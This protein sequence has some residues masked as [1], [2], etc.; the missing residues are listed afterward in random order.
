MRQMVGEELGIGVERIELIEGDTALTP[1]QGRQRAAPASCAAAWRCARPRRRRARRCS[2][3]PPS[4]LAAPAAELTLADGEVRPGRRRRASRFAEL[5]GERGFDVK[6]NPKAPLKRPSH[7]CWS[8][9]R[10]RAPTCRPRSPVARLRPRPRRPRNAARPRAAAAGGRREGRGGRRILG[11]ALPGVRV[12]RIA[13]FVGVVAA[14]E[15][16]AVR[17][18]RELKVRWS[19]ERALIGNDALVDWVRAGPF[20]AEETWSPRA[21]RK[22]ALADAADA[23]ARRR[24]RGRSSRT[25]RSALRARSPTCAPTAARCGRRRRRRHRFLNM[26]AALVDLP[27]DKLR[28]I[29]LDGAGCYGM[30][31]HDDAA[32]DAVLLSKAVGKP[33]RVQWSREDELGWDPKGPPQLLE[34]RRADRRRP[35]RCLADRDVGAARHRQSRRCRCSRR[36]AAGMR[37][38]AGTRRAGHAE[39]RSAVRGRAIRGVGALA[40]AGA[41]AAIQHPRAGQGRATASRSR[42]SSTSS[43]PRRGADPL[44]FRLRDLADPRGVEVLRRVAR[45]DRLAA[46]AVAGA[47]AQGGA[48]P[49]HGLHPLQE[50]RDL[51]RDRDGGRGRASSGEIRVRRVCC[52]HDCGLMINPD[53]VRAQVEGNILQTLSRTLYEETTFDRSRVTSV[54]W[55]SYRLLRFPE[56]P[57]PDRPRRRPSSRRSAPAR[58]RRARCRRRW[59]TRCSTPPAC[60]C[61][62]FRSRDNGCWRR[63]PR[64]FPR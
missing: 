46:A 6:M 57:R 33:V 60:A 39:R 23:L 51:R 19:D 1:N 43:P 58:R 63:W 10:C 14:D 22:A 59:P 9:S 21:T 61:A 49:R 11:R 3:S 42:A 2:G 25:A 36:V 15:W 52:A 18:A 24:T 48:R 13:D 45:D 16:A 54:D 64:R 53:A 50:Q 26:F 29:Y 56:V 32:A 27:R 30:N 31:G 38:P 35:H 55:S 4:A 5:V 62:A 41:A 7:T 20:V 17:A 47:G 12:V 28:V 44:A 34:L 37:Q 40:R 8:A